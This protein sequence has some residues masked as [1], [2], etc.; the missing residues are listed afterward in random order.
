MPETDESTIRAQIGAMVER[1]P[2]GALRYALGNN[3]RPHRTLPLPPKSASNPPAPSGSTAKF[4]SS[5][6]MANPSRPATASP[7]AA[8]APQRT[9]PSATAPTA[10]TAS[11]PSPARPP[12]PTYNFQCDDC[13]HAF[14]LKRP[15]SQAGD[16]RHLP[17]KTAPAPIASSTP[18]PFSAPPAVGRSRGDPDARAERAQTADDRADAAG[19]PHAPDY[20]GRDDPA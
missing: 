17:P 12:M 11:N 9:N 8:A 7:S 4:K 10:T 5:A 18:A 15:M 13:G 16:P 6:P 3:P 2:S 19:A 20:S 14:E 1:C